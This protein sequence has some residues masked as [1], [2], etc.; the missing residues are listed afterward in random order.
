MFV[1]PLQKPRVLTLYEL[2]HKRNALTQKEMRQYF[3]LKKGF[4]GEKRIYELINSLSGD[5]LALHDLLLSSNNQTF[6]VDFLLVIDGT[7]H[8]FEVKN[9]HG[10]FYFDSD[11][12]FR[13]P[14]TEISNPVIQ[15]IRTESLL[16]Q[17]LQQY[18]F[19]NSIQSTVIFTNP[20]FTLFYAPRKKEFLLPT[21]LNRFFQNFTGQTPIGAAH[22]DL[23]ET[24]QSLHISESP[25]QLLPSYDFKQIKKGI[26]CH[27][28]HTL[29]TFVEKQSC[30]CQKC[31]YKE[32]LEK[33]IIR[34]IQEHQLLFPDQKMTTTRIRE[35]CK[36]VESNWRIRRVLNKCFAQK[37]KRKWA[38]Y[39]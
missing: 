37:G 6:Q 8:L 30:I 12:F 29:T 15:L 25:Y 23:T 16:R 26:P 5:Y 22:K 33:A 27:Q 1:K 19:Q 10:E 13:V 2:L 3:Q 11:R 28:C 9:Y 14:Q 4:E 32:P 34:N 38:Y 17:L 35:W 39:E 36:I 31:D 20:E 21:Q 24:L 7:L 18:G